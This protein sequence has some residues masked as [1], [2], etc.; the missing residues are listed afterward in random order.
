M[1]LPDLSMSPYGVRKMKLL[2]RDILITFSDQM[3][4]L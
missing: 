2:I 1:G 3:A 4:A